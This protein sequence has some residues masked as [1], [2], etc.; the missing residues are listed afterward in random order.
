MENNRESVCGQNISR[1]VQNGCEMEC[2]KQRLELLSNT[3][4]SHNFYN[5]KSRF[6]HSFKTFSFKQCSYTYLKNTIFYQSLDVS[7]LFSNLEVVSYVLKL[8]IISET[9]TGASAVHFARQKCKEAKTA[10]HQKLRTMISPEV[11]GIYYINKQIV[12]QFSLDFAYV[13][14][15]LPRQYCPQKYQFLVYKTHHWVQ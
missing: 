15:Q 1:L 9:Y 4:F 6:V 5:L 11:K 13:V 7:Q 10:K 2:F 3:E 8:F 12:L 14:I